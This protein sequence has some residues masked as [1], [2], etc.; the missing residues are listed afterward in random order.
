MDPLTSMLV[1]G[2]APSHYEVHSQSLR[3]AWDG[4][5]ASLFLIDLVLNKSIFSE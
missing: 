5:L 2:S 4:A 1:Q 3:E